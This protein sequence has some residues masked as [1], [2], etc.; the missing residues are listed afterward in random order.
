MSNRNPFEYRGYTAT[1][2]YDPSNDHLHGRVDDIS[3]VI[4]FEARSL[5]ELQSEFRESV[6]WYIELC[7]RRGT[8][9]E[10]PYSGNFLVRA[11]PD[12]HR[13]LVQQARRADTSLNAL[14]VDHLRTLVTA[15]R[16]PHTQTAGITFH[17][18]WKDAG[19]IRT[20]SSA[21]E[22]FVELPASIK[23]P[24]RFHPGGEDWVPVG[25][26]SQRPQRTITA[27]KSLEEMTHGR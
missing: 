4:T 9:P 24:E 7:E 19:R 1:I 2:E 5:D 15:A 6:D 10:R 18:R 12:L 26:S 16:K 3:D 27:T 17:G 13:A 23:K 14:V 8:E 22:F 25:S 20:E 21:G 11:T